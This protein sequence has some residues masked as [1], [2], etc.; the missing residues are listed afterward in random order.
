MGILFWHNEGMK[1]IRGMVL[2]GA[3]LGCG[4]RQY[5]EKGE[6]YR[7][8]KKYDPHLE[9]MIPDNILSG[10]RC[11]DYGEGCKGVFK[12]KHRKVSMICVEYESPKQA[13]HFGQSIDAYIV[14]NWLL[15]DVSGEPVLEEFVE[16]ALRGKKA[17]SYPLF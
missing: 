12:I 2:L 9:L 13:I 3:L 16:K 14:R 1:G 8:G 5:Y 6:F 10:P 4:E 11:G 15:D 17:R 7:L